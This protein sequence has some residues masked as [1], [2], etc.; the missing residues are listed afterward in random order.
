VWEENFD[1]LNTDRWQPEHS[2]YGDGNGERQCYRPE[3]VAVAGGKLILTAR[4]ETYSCPR[5]GTRT[6]TSGMVRSRGLGFSPGQAIEFRVK[7]TP[8]DPD[9][10]AGLWPAVWAS[11]W[12]G[13][14]WPSGGEMD[15]LEVMTAENPRR[16]MHSIHYA[17]PSDDHALKNRGAY[18]DGYFSD[19]WHTIRFDYGQGGRLRWYLDGRPVFEVTAADTL[20]GY[21]AP[22]DQTVREIKINLATGGTPGPLSW[23][24][25]GSSGATF[26][27]DYIK[28]WNL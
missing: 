12:T 26:E 3:N 27:V 4:H 2:S 5:T 18:L 25:L 21:P 19:E 24:A 28:V 11:S 6:V 14:K 9:D 7:L 1:Q 8:A 15:W 17:D 22:F 10:Q 13:D 20:Q 16:S 23:G